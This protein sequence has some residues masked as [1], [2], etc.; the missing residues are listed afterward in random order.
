MGCRIRAILHWKLSAS[1]V[2]KR[3][4]VRRAREDASFEFEN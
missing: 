1:G 2:D 4:H 3:F